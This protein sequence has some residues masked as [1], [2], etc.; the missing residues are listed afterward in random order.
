MVRIPLSSVDKRASLK[1]SEKGEAEGEE[2]AVAFV[3]GVDSSR[4][5]DPTGVAFSVSSKLG[6]KIE[7]EGGFDPF[8][9]LGF[10][11]TASIATKR[12]D[13]GHTTS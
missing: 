2:G 1:P 5:E 9:A 6:N 7:F 4:G 3:R 10:A 8:E 11:A 12:T 13:S